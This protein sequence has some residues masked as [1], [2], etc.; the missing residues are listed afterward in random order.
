MQTFLSLYRFQR[1]V[2]GGGP[3]RF[4]VF[5]QLMQKEGGKL[6]AFHGLLGP[7]DVMVL[8]QYPSA[9]AAAKG[10]SAVG[11]LI[12]AECTTMPALEEGDFL[13]LLAELNAEAVD[14]ASIQ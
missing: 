11:N 14:P 2:K 7:Y 3:A 9:R 5:K 1:P 4:E 13:T 12:R 6:L 10:A 8:A